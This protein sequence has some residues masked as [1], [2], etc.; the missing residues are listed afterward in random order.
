MH[1]VG[2]GY[3]LGMRA[4]SAGFVLSLVAS[5]AVASAPG[6]ATAPAPATCDERSWIGGT[7][8]WCT[9]AL[10]YRDYVYD[11]AGADT[12]P[13]GSPHGTPLNR[14]RGDVDHRD[15]G[16]SLNSADIL[17]F[18]MR[19]YGSQLRIAARLNTLFSKDKTV[20]AV[21]IDTDDDRST[22]GGIWDER[23]SVSSD[24]WDVVGVFGRRDPKENVITGSMPLPPVRSKTWRIQAVT[25]LGDG[26]V[27]NVAFRPRETGDWWEDA[28]A[29]ALASGDIS[30]FG[31]RIKVVDL[32]A[33]T[34]HRPAAARGPGLYERVYTSNYPIKEGINYNGVTPSGVRGTYHYLGSHQPY[35]IYVPKPDPSKTYGVQLALHGGS[36]NHSSLVTFEGMQYAFGDFLRSLGDKPRL[37][38]V[39]LGRG[40]E[41]GYVDYGER[42]VFDVLADVYR[43]YP[44]DKARVFAGGYSMGG[45]GT[46]WLTSLY[47]HRF[48]GGITWVGH[49]ADCLNGTPF[50]QGRQR[51]DPPVDGAWENEPPGCAG[52]GNVFDYLE[53]T[54]HV[55]MGMVYAGGDEFVWPTQALAI[56]ERYADL[57]Y[58][59]MWW[60]LPAAEHLT[61]ALLDHWLKEAAWSAN[62]TRVTRPAHVTYRTNP[63]FWH[64]KIGLQQD[65]AYWVQDVRPAKPS[66]DRLGDISVDLI[67]HRC[68]PHILYG[69]DI[70]YAAGPDPVPWVA[71]QGTPRRVAGI[72]Q[73]DVITGVVRNASSITI[74]PKGACMGNGQIKLDI[75][76]DGPT[77]VHFTDGRPDEIL[78][79]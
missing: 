4:G 1:I 27:M 42:D 41:N 49:T 38:V 58:E 54:R 11:D 39:P 71:Q 20:L 76:V 66:R 48:T 24:G 61:P 16:Q 13:F 22:G 35:A 74:D 44:V 10:V 72:S 69:A 36:A 31:Q 78:R 3:N 6:A 70:S 25:A 57:Q 33:G 55:P 73:G 47:P 29:Q 45:A 5:F 60:F 64:Q 67:S 37:I 17:T 46:Y 19:R 53:N 8:E 77:V 32:M 50:A 51:P 30:T 18:R 65:S 75:A 62:R 21:A 28:Q 40:P 26:T 59:H 2:S 34:T 15:H 7:T 12:R 68:P 79:P 14:A 63:Y 23:V 52:E 56:R 9:G 43:H